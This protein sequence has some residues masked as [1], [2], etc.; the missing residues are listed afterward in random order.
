MSA[1]RRVS[2]GKETYSK[3]D[4][5]LG[6][7]GLPRPVYVYECGEANLD[8][9]SAK[10]HIMQLLILVAHF[11]RSKWEDDDDNDDDDDDA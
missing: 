8:M 9:S 3:A 1:R 10:H 2:G 4:L 11:N 5:G 6:I 7:T